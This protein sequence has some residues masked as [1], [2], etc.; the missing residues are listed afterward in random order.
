MNRRDV[1]IC[2][3]GQTNI[4]VDVIP[5]NARWGGDISGAYKMMFPTM[6]LQFWY[7]SDC[8]SWNWS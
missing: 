3:R 2:T 7:W 1:C 4:M 8:R 6:E 5:F